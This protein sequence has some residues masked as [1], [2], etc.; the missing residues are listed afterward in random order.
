MHPTHVTLRRRPA[1]RRDRT[2]RRRL[3]AFIVAV[4]VVLLGASGIAAAHGDV[5]QSSVSTSGATSWGVWAGDE[6]SLVQTFTPSRSPLTGL[7]LVLRV[8]DFNGEPPDA[9]VRLTQTIGGPALWQVTIS[10]EDL[11]PSFATVHLDVSPTLSVTPGST[12]VIEVSPAQDVGGELWSEVRSGY[13]GGG[14][15]WLT[16]DTSFFDRCADGLTNSDLSFQT[17][18]EAADSDSDGVPDGV[19]NCP[20]VVNSD[21]ANFDGDV[22][23]DACDVDDDNDGVAD[24]VDAFPFNQSESVDADNDLVGDNADNCP[25]QWNGLQEDL[26]EDGQ[27]DLCDL[28][29]DGDGYSDFYEFNCL[30]YPATLDPTRVPADFD[31]DLIPDCIDPDDDNDGI[32][33]NIDSFPFDPTRGQD[34]DGDGF[35][36][37][38]DNCPFTW[39]ADQ[40][41]ADGDGIGDVCDT[42]ADN[43]GVD[44]ATDNCPNT[45]NAGQGDVDGDGIG[46]ACDP[47]DDRDLTPPTIVCPAETVSV[48]IGE[49]GHVTVTPADVGVMASDDVEL[50][51]LWVNPNNFS[52]TGL[53]EGIVASAIDTSL[54]TALCTF[55]IEVLPIDLD[56]DG[57]PDGSDNCPAV[58]NADQANFDGDVDGDA[59]DPDD[60][61]D[62]VDDADDN[63]PVDA[64]GDQSDVDGDGIGDVCD[65][66]DDRDLTPPTIECPSATV[67]V[68]IGEAGSVTVTPEDV[69]V[70]AIDDVEL[71]SVV[72]A[73][74]EFTSAGLFEGVTATATDSSGNEATCTFDID[75]LP[76]DMDADGDGVHDDV[77][78]CPGTTLPDDEPGN[79]KRHRYIANEFGD[80]VDRN[81]HASGITI[82]HTHGC[83]SAQIHEALGHPGYTHKGSSIWT[84]VIW[85]WLAPF[86][87]G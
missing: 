20:S 69:G 75:V 6:V 25:G 66:V 77:D 46:D 42:D 35:D 51:G 47:T 62:G 17:Y 54:N 53:F 30:D 15:C 45:A 68:T 64:N 26:D 2:A 71:V 29:D 9:L 4:L 58:A 13:E 1:L 72:V 19:D 12:Y 67:S 63:C 8:G 48:V 18:S 50:A 34:A 74:N 33:D 5:D 82:V 32:N 78:F 85:A 61:N 73:P 79:W 10:A 83:T 27:G 57:V 21:Q 86:F 65:P 44:N 59:C 55:D 76:I 39:N 80:F 81:G 7:D 52:V 14:A 60:D 84:L 41:D 36:D 37:N 16:S 70:T 22:E 3:P 23:G 38:E 87:F 31:G 28:D 43:D 24:V 49:S 40:S 11:G 56:G